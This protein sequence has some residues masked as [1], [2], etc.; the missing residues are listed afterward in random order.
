MFHPIG[1]VGSREPNTWKRDNISLRSLEQALQVFTYLQ[2]ARHRLQS[3]YASEVD[4]ILERT[5]ANQGTCCNALPVGLDPLRPCICHLERDWY[6][7]KDVTMFNEL[8]LKCQVRLQVNTTSDPGGKTNISKDRK[9]TRKLALLEW[10]WAN[11]R[12]P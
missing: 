1:E 6:W 4:A 2:E 7:T 9:H 10:L 12:R 8:T 5:H 3:S 11:C